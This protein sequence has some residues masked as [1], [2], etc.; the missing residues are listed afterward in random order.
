[1]RAVNKYIIIDQIVEEVKASS[2][3]ILSAVETDEMRYGK[4]TIVSTGN[5]VVAVSAGQVIYFDKRAGHQVR[6]EGKVYGIIKESDVV[7][8]LEESDLRA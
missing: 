6:L 1:M 8:V 3:L 5:E 4:G 7:V 2:G